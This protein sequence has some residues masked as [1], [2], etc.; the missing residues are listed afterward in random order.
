MAFPVQI[1]ANIG[2]AGR[3]QNA[4]LN[5]HGGIT[6]LLGPNGSGKT[7]L[8]RAAKQD[9]EQLMRQQPIDGAPPLNKKVRFISAGRIGLLEQYRADYDGRQGSNPQYDNAQY[10]SKKDASRRHGFETL[11]GDILTL[12]Q[13]PD[14][15]VKIRERLRKLFQRDVLVDWDA[16]SL[17][18]SFSRLDGTNTTYSSGREA[19]GLMHPTVC[20][21]TPSRAP[22]NLRFEKGALLIARHHLVR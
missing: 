18:L 2:P 8:L 6:V 10:G 5:I 14:I 21:C 9:L 3:A 12:S 1:N 11:Q 19:S 13:R 7:Q 16:G 4:Q 20:S 15:L 22:S 17:K